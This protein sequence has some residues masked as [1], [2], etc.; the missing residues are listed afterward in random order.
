MGS[1][2]YLTPSLCVWMLLGARDGAWYPRTCL[3]PKTE[4]IVP[5]SCGASTGV[6]GLCL[7]L[8]RPVIPLSSHF[9]GF[10]FLYTI[11][12]PI[13]FMVGFFFLPA[14][15][16][17]LFS[18]SVKSLPLPL[19][20]LSFTLLR[21]PILLMRCPKLNSVQLPSHPGAVNWNKQCPV[22]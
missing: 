15:H 17:S 21:I 8:P 13:Y 16:T 20:I 5:S 11:R 10:S 22:S 14:L 19:T 12:R 7:F 1:S 4:T 3:C 2:S 9:T 6:F 18:S